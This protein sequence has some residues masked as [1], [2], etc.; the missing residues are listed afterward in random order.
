MKYDERLVWIH[1]SALLSS[2][3][4]SLNVKQDLSG[5]SQCRWHHNTTIFKDEGSGSSIWS[6]LQFWWLYSSVCRSAQ[7]H[8]KNIGR[9]RQLYSWYTCLRYCV[10]CRLR[11]REECGAWD[12]RCRWSVWNVHMFGSSRVG[13][14]WIV[15]GLYQSCGNRGSLERVSVFGLR[16]SGW[17]W[18]TG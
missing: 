7:L 11:A 6:V 3:L 2:Y 4:C 15:F 8:L 17:Y 10:Q 14:E 13:A 18:G 9:I 12:E 5:I 16:C 1:F